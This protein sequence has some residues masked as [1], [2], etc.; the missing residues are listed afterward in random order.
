MPKKL[1]VHGSDFRCAQI[2]SNS[3]GCYM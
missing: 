3:I 2:C 1:T